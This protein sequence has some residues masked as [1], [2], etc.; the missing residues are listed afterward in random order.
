M[1]FF[2]RRGLALL[3]TYRRQG[4]KVNLIFQGFCGSYFSLFFAAADSLGFE[5]VK[6]T[7]PDEGLHMGRALLTKLN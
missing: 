2:S 5:A 1:M 7:G 3:L 4:V 6:V